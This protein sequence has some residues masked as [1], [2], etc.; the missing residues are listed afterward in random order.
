MVDM[1]NGDVIDENSRLYLQLFHRW[2]DIWSEL[3]NESSM[4]EPVSLIADEIFEKETGVTRK[5][6]MLSSIHDYSVVD[7]D[8]LTRWRMSH[9]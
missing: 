5:K 1:K 8:K 9:I 2:S 4:T 3:L 7:V 6:N